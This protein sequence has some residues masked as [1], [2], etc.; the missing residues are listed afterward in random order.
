[1]LTIDGIS[2]ALVTGLRLLTDRFAD[3]KPQNNELFEEGFDVRVPWPELQR[4][5]AFVQISHARI[6]TQIGRDLW[7]N[8]TYETQLLVC[9]LSVFGV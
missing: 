5:G 1:V 3:G 4:R 7:V 6:L 2:Y 8:E 9:G